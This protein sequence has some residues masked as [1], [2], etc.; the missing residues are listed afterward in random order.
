MVFVFVIPNGDG[1]AD[2]TAV[3]TVPKVK[4][5]A[6]NDDVV[7]ATSDGVGVPKHNKPLDFGVLKSNDGVVELVVVVVDNAAPV[8]ATV[9]VAVKL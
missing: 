6:G 2:A 9:D 7:P 5:L 3:E 4:E 1:L 8:D